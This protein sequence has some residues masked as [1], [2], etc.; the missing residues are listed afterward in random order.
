[1][2]RIESIN[3]RSRYGTSESEVLFVPYYLQTI[4]RVAFR[5]GIAMV[6]KPQLLYPVVH[7]LQGNDHNIL[8]IDWQIDRDH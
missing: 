4:Y 2:C 8:D 1:M 5:E 6:E 3:H 7:V